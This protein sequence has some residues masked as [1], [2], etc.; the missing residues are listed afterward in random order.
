MTTLT[1][2]PKTSIFSGKYQADPVHSYFGFA[3]RYQGV[4]LFRGTFSEVEAKLSEEEGYLSLWG[5]A[6]VE[7]ISITTPQ[8][9]RDHVLSEEFFYAQEHPN[10][11]FRSD[12]I[13]LEE[14]GTAV[15]KGELTIRGET[16]DVTARAHIPS[17]MKTPLGTCEVL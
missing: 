11:T 6:A 8:A 15:V 4:S 3:V 7:G 16:R 13:Q 1:A 9:F 12:D 2:P 10:I 5:Q 17:P 14:D